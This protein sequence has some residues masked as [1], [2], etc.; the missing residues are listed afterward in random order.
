MGGLFFGNRDIN[1]SIQAATRFQFGFLNKS[2]LVTDEDDVPF[3]KLSTM[4]ELVTVLENAKTGTDGIDS[5]TDFITEAA[6]GLL[7]DD[8]ILFT[9]LMGGTGLVI[10]TNY[11]VIN[12]TTDTFQLSATQGGANIDITA[13]STSFT[14]KRLLSDTAPNLIAAV[15]IFLGQ[16]DNSG[17]A[18]IP[19]YFYV[20]GATEADVTNSI[21][22]IIT[23][24]T[25]ATPA[26][27][28]YNMV[29]VFE[30]IPW[31]TWVTTWGVTNKRISMIYT[32]GMGPWTAP[33][34]SP[35]I[36]SIFDMQAS[37]EWKNAA[38]SGRVISYASL[39][40]FK[41]KKLTGM[42]GDALSD[43]MVS[44]L[45]GNGRNGYRDVRGIGETTGSRTTEN[46]AETGSYIDTIIIRDNIIYNVAGALHDIFRQNEIIPMGDGGRV[47]VIQAISAALNFLG[48][49]GLI[50]QF[51]NGS[52]Q[53]KV[54]VPDITSAMR[55]ARELTG[56]VFEY[57]P[58]I[59]MEKITVTGKELLEWIEGGVA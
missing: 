25:S 11:Y 42:T 35:R 49:A 50:N 9:E 47:M 53:Y 59:P 15:T 14:Y 17:N 23:L 29:P 56:V 31:N 48:G 22:L 1:V 45:E 46:V 41:W 38:W 16:S 10:D 26:N 28:F 40:A 3:T 13:D 4:A 7:D 27:D 12:K 36:C 43:A 58:T 55:S 8:I 39:I 44:S 5:T 30:S 51:E 34:K 24:I 2:L 21:S 52:Y 57:V 20:V 6:H 18:V 37:P 19:E 33:E 54:T 32:T